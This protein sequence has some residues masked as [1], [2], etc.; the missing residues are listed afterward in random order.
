LVPDY[1]ESIG[2]RANTNVG[3]LA[4]H[5]ARIPSRFGVR[6]DRALSL[7]GE[8]DNLGAVAD[9]GCRVRTTRKRA[10]SSPAW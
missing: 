4:V 8:A 2:H 3:R 7:E 1:R 5:D 9:A 10:A 6:T